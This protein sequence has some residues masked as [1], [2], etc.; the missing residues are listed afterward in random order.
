MRLLRLAEKAV[1]GLDIPARQT[2]SS[3]IGW[4]EGIIDEKLSLSL[5]PGNQ[6]SQQKDVVCPGNQAERIISNT[7]F[8][9]L[10]A[11]LWDQA[12]PETSIKYLRL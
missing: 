5:A 10:L 6:R 3:Y 11:W 9:L 7:V 4:L 1:D 2:S 8:L 12:H